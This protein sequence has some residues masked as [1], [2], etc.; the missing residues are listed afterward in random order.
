MSRCQEYSLY[1]TTAYYRNL[2]NGSPDR[3]DLLR[4]MNTTRGNKVTSLA[5]KVSVSVSLRGSGEVE[6]HR[7][8]AIG[9]IHRLLQFIL[10]WMPWMLVLDGTPQYRIWG[11]LRHFHVSYFRR[12]G[13]TTLGLE[14]FDDVCPED[15]RSRFVRSYGMLSVQGSLGLDCH[16]PQIE[17]W[18]HLQ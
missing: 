12:W 3:R 5:N 7:A 10:R 17:R 1:P 4:R 14:D 11:R 8:F 16:G 13:G 6:R 18:M 9:N 2:R 15:I